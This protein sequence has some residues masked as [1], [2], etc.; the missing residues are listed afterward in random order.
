MQAEAAA[1]CAALAEELQA[2]QASHT[3]AAQQAQAELAAC[4]QSAAAALA[5]RPLPEDL[6][7]VSGPPLEQNP[8]CGEHHS[9]SIASRHRRLL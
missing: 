9:S 2:A 1:R 8:P 4:Q 3:E 5:S 7:R 6:E